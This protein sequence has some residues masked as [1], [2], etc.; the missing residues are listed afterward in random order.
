METNSINPN[1]VNEENKPDDSVGPGRMKYEKP[2]LGKIDLTAQEI[3]GGCKTEMS[4]IGEAMTA[5]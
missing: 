1:T 5:S 3:L 2:A 4:C